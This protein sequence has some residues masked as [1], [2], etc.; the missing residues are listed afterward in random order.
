VTIFSLSKERF[1]VE[2]PCHDSEVKGYEEARALAHE[3]AEG[4]E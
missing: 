3:L 2:A 4:L 1:R